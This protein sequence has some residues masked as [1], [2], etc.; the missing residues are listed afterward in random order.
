MPVMLRTGATGSACARTRG[1]PPTCRVHGLSHELEGAYSTPWQ[2]LSFSRLPAAMGV[3]EAEFA[4]AQEALLAATNGR[5]RLVQPIS[6]GAFGMVA[7][8]R[9][10]CGTDVAVKCLRLG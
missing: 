3:D 7:R 8:A 1:A 10:D 6:K 9:V 2:C 4:A 5:Y